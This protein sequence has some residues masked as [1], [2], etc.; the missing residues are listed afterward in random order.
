[1]VF[2]G[3]PLGRSGVST[4]IAKSSS[5]SDSEPTSFKILIVSL[6][7]IGCFLSSRSHR[8]FRNP[9]SKGIGGGV[10]LSLTQSSKASLTAFVAAF[11]SCTTSGLSPSIT[12]ILLFSFFCS[13][14]GCCLHFL[15]PAFLGSAL[16]SGM[17]GWTASA[18]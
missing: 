16:K 11:F 8:L 13:L 14:S 4:S 9:V 18:K 5:I 10:S 7:E 17:L 15:P 2:T 3:F 6:L 1:M 12:D